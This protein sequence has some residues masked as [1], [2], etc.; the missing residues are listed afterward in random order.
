V[1]NGLAGYGYGDVSGGFAYFGGGGGGLGGGATGGTSAGATANTG[2]GGAGGNTQSSQKGSAGGSGIA[3]VQY[4]YNSSASAGSLTLSGGITLGS[5]TSTLDAYGS[6]GLVDVTGSITGTGALNIASSANTGGVVRFS[7]NN[8]YTGTTTLL[9]NSTLVLNTNGTLA[10]TNISLGLSSTTQGTL[11]L[12]ATAGFTLATNQTL[13]G[14]GT[15]TLGTLNTLTLNGGVSPGN[16]TLSKSGIINVTGNVVLGSTSITTLQLYGTNAGNQYDQLI[17][18]GGS[19]TYGG[20]LDL[21]VN[22]NTYTPGA[23]DNYNLFSSWGGGYNPGLTNVTIVGNM[24]GI[25]TFTPQVGGEWTYTDTYNTVWTFSEL[26]GQ[27]AVTAVPEPQ[28]LVFLGG[29]VSA[30]VLFYRRRK[31]RQNS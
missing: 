20:T 22:T 7:T 15:V 14:S 10:S 26:N 16:V 6:G 23:G 19:L 8:T 31:A 30:V 9:S 17:G 28:D 25:G 5:G 11:D 29:A 12:T 3:V 27:L 21:L 2:G 24:P 13:S 1:I 4:D 18:T